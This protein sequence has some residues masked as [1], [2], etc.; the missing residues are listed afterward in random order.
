MLVVNA[1]REC[2][3]CS[4]N[5]Q[6]MGTVCACVK[7]QVFRECLRAYHRA[8]SAPQQVVRGTTLQ[9]ELTGCDYRAD[10][11]II[12]KHV[13]SPRDYQLLLMYHLMG[14]G[15]RFCA[16]RLGCVNKFQIFSLIGFLEAKLGAAFAEASPIALY[17]VTEYFEIERSA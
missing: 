11:Q 5:G 13:L 4:G 10:F 3:F 14:M 8:S 12:A 2:R 16:G 6:R 7:R 9:V 17:P 15:W 1:D